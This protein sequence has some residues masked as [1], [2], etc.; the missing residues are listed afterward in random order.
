MSANTVK[1]SNAKA[2][3]V[4][5]TL[6]AQLGPTRLLASLLSGEITTHE[7]FADTCAQIREIT[8]GIEAALLIGVTLIGV[9]DGNAR[10]AGTEILVPAL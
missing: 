6:A 10:N 3:A 8:A 5:N 2:E 4:E 1:I 7:G 9:P